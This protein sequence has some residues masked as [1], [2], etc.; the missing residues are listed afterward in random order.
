V[1]PETD[2]F[3]KANLRRDST[4]A[5]AKAEGEK[6]WARPSEN[7]RRRP[8]PSS[9]RYPHRMLVEAVSGRSNF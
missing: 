6:K 2:D 3:L 7:Q 4:A 9:F 1:L 5:L 8:A